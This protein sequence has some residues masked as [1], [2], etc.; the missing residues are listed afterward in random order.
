[1]SSTKRMKRAADRHET[2]SDTSTHLPG[3]Y[4]LTGGDVTLG[5]VTGQTTRQHNGR[6]AVSVTARVLDFE[7]TLANWEGRDAA[8]G[9]V[10][11][12][13]TYPLPLDAIPASVQIWIQGT[14]SPV[15]CVDGDWHIRLWFTDNAGRQLTW[16]CLAR[17]GLDGT[18]R[19]SAPL[20]ATLEVDDVHSAASPRN[21][22]GAHK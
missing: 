18:D 20:A 11:P 21:P 17:P 1:M 12:L 22:T 15:S 16:R 6:S 8:P 3:S 5:N 4:R 9:S 10:L 2:M 14:P 13:T 7:V 19:F